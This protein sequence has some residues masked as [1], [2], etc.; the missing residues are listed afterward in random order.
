MSA[1]DGIYILRTPAWPIKKDNTYI[2][3]Y[4]KFEYRV[5][6]C[7]AI[8]NIHYS[9]LYMVSYFGNS[10]V[11]SDK[12]KAIEFASDILED[13]GWTEYGIHIIEVDKYFPNMTVMAARQALDCYVGAKPF[14]ADKQEY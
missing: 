10:T 13:I 8:E 3:Q 7:Q 11:W 4:D 1:D 2:N 9:D 14:D 5:A 12:A 6:H